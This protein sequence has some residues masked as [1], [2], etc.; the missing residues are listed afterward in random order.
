MIKCILSS[1][2]VRISLTRAQIILVMLLKLE[3]DIVDDI[4]ENCKDKNF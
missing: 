3:F 2:Y 4:C 1:T